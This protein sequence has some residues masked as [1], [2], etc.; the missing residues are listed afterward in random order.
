VGGPMSEESLL[1]LARQVQN[2]QPI[3]LPSIYQTD[4]PETP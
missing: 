4:P 1:A 3:G 2:A